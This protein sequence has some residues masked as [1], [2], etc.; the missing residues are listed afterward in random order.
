MSWEWDER[1]EPCPCGKGTILVRDGSDDWFR[2]EHTE[3][4]KCP[5]CRDRYVYAPLRARPDRSWG[6]I[7][8]AE[9]E[10]REAAREAEE[11]RQEEL[12]AKARTRYGAAFVAA[13]SRYT[14]R[15]AVWDALREATY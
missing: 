6:W 9:Y 8:K 5:T 10:R 13:L 12:T 3:E 11:R 1:E 4:M 14:S 7:P 15:K 2:S